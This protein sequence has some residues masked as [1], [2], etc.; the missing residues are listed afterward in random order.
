MCC[1]A[2]HRELPKGKKL[3]LRQQHHARVMKE[4]AR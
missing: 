4:R 2:K 1:V 3:K